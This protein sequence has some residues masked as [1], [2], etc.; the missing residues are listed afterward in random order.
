MSLTGGLTGLG[1]MFLFNT[2]RSLCGHS[3]TE[4]SEATWISIKSC[5]SNQW[6]SGDIPKWMSGWPVDHRAQKQ[7][8]RVYP[9]I[10]RKK[11]RQ[12]KEDSASQEKAVYKWK[13][14]LEE[15][16]SYLMRT[17]FWLC[18]EIQGRRKWRG[19]GVS[20]CA[21]AEAACLGTGVLPPPRWRGRAAACCQGTHTSDRTLDRPSCSWAAFHVV[22]RVSRLQMLAHGWDEERRAEVGTGNTGEALGGYG[23]QGWCSWGHF[24]FLKWVVIALNG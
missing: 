21:Q 16:K 13:I 19:Q 9:Q 5:K 23:E 24:C 4:V 8:P 17:H 15:N 12:R 14:T 18:L 2:S 7:P 20:R 10:P 22:W 3:S 11:P 6:V 1:Q